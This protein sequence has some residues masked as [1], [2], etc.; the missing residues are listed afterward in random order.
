MS[1]EANTDD[2]DSTYSDLIDAVKSDPNRET[3]EKETAIYFSKPDDRITVNT[4]ERALMRRLLSHPEFVLD[5]YETSHGGKADYQS[6]TAAE[7]AERGGHDA[8]KPVYSVTGTMPIGVLKIAASSRKS[9]GHADVIS[10][11]VLD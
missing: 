8:R 2:S 4:A 9:T 7:Y 3:V 1:D 11:G 6:V 5:R 10:A